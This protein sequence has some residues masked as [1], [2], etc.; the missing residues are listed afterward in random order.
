MDRLIAVVF[1]LYV[2]SKGCGC[3]YNGDVYLYS[4]QGEEIS[5]EKEVN[6]DLEL[7]IIP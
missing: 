2:I 5:V 4:P 3:A 6:A 1:A 7:P